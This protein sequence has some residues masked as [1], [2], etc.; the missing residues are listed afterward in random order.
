[1]IDI[2]D[3]GKFIAPILLN[4]DKYNG[5]SFT[6]ATAF[7]TPQQLIEGWTNVTG[8]NVTYEQI[9]EARGN[10]TA[11]MSGELKKSLG[12]I[13][14]HSYFGPNGEKDL[15]WTLAQ[16]EETP[17]NWEQFLRTNGSRFVGA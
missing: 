12:L 6:C 8:K 7:Y 16:M 4:P 9:H 14:I 15:E 11:E 3:T 10:L 17:N 2:T 5:K 1:M 13:D